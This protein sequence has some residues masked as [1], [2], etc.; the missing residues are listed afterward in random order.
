MSR[1]SSLLKHP[2]LPAIQVKL[3]KRIPLRT[4][5]AEHGVTTACLSRYRASHMLPHFIAQLLA[6]DGAKTA[7]A[8]L[9]ESRDATEMLVSLAQGYGVLVRETVEERAP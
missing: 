9:L 7:L 6:V 5:A 2:Q 1:R 8:H 3:A 4:I